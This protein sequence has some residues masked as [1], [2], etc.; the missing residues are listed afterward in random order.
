MDISVVLRRHEIAEADH[1]ILNPFTEAG[2]SLL[3]RLCRLHPGSR[4]LDLACGKGELLCT[5]AAEHRITGL[6]V[7]LSEVFLSA[8]QARADELGVAGTAGVAGQVRFE[9]ADAAA[10]AIE[11][12][13]WD[14]AC[15]IGATWIGGG[16][17][18]TAAMLRRA[19]RPGGLVLI[20]EPYWRREPPDA[21]YQALPS[22]PEEWTTLAGTAQRL[23][24]AGLELVELLTA[25]EHSWDR[26]EASQWWTVT[27][28][29]TA[30][31]D[32]PQAAEMR[33]FLDSGRS[34][35]LTYGHDLLGWGVFVTRA[36]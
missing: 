4:L 35:Y 16:L 8:A 3:G 12:G 10:F 29:L 26:Y 33:E 31:P 6:G 28:W 19:V 21:A 7:D 2:L 17:S 5:W 20:G 32:H 23:A 11:P 15:C 22:G 27:A 25:D 9:R 36:V 13:S 34:T 24:Q 30:N 1:R 18:G 14:V